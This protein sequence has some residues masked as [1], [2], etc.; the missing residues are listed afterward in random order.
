MKDKRIEKT[1]RRVVLCALL[2]LLLAISACN[3]APKYATPPAAAP[4]AYKESPP[5]LFK[6]GEGWK[7]AQP[8]DDHLPGNWWEIFKDP[9]L[10]ALEIQ[11]KVSNQTIIAAEAN[12]RAARALVVSAHS[13]LYPTINTAPSYSVGQSSKNLH[14]ATSGSG[15]V[16]STSG[17]VVNLFSLPVEVSYTPDFWHRIRNTVAANAYA[18]QASAADI[19]TATLSTQAQLA[20]FYFELRAVDAQRQI[21]HDTVGS[22][23]EALKLTDTLYKLGIDSEQDVVQARLQ[24]DTATAQERDLGVNRATFE[25]AMAILIGVPPANFSVA[26]APFNPNPPE[27]PVVVPSILLERRPDIASAERTVAAANA[28]IGVA[29]AAYYPSLTLSASAGL[30]ASSFTQWFSWPSRFWSLGPAQLTQTL[31][32]G[33]ARR[34]Q[35]DQAN[36]QYDAAVADYRQTVLTAF[37]AVEDNLGTLRILTEELREQRRAVQSAARYLDLATTRYKAGVDSYLNVI[38]AQTSLLTNRETEVSIEERRM[39]AS[40]LLTQAVGGG[41]DPAT[42][43]QVRDM[44]AKPPKWSPPAPLNGTPVPVT[45]PNPAPLPDRTATGTPGANP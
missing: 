13:G 37:Q 3:P 6:E 39:M 32:D 30:E 44:L 4:T 1:E 16:S 42:L 10:N 22:Y 28:N 11:V 27:V 41:W 29:R 43:P 23:Q 12:Y 2:S 7:L 19:A 35:N 33:G 20:T 31:Y 17:S 5:D 26:G 25:H 45:A 15:P 38:T 18:A 36:A 21:L 9:E 40:V 34:A 8:G 24:L 14:G